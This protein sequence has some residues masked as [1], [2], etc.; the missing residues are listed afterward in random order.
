MSSIRGA[1]AYA[2]V[3]VESGILSASPH[4]RIVMLFDSYQASI[5]VA[6]LHM[7]AGNIAEKGNAITK[8]I[9]IVS[10]GLRAS[11]DH[12][13]GGEIAVQLDALYDYVV[14]LLLRANLNNDETA[15]TTAADLLSNV[16]AAWSAIGSPIEQE[17]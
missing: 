10:K 1:N 6:R 12:E 7:Q 17:R 8:A 5:R 4:Q 11:L 16:A 2:K 3:G 13:Q 14:R 15:L 9:N